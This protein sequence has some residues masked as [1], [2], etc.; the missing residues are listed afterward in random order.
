MCVNLQQI[1]SEYYVTDSAAAVS[2]PVGLAPIISGTYAV[3]LIL[4]ASIS[5][6]LCVCVIQAMYASNTDKH[7]RYN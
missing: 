3:S 6:F 1:R 2:P 5:V 7:T 4:L